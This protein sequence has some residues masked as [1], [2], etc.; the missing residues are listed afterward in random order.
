M[1]RLTLKNLAGNR[2]RFALTAFAVVLAVSFVVASFI[3]TDGLRAQF[4]GLSTEIVGG[5]DLAVRPVEG[6]FGRTGPLPTTMLA[7]VA[8]V[9]G[10]ANASP[11]LGGADN[12]IRP[13]KPDGSLISA[14]GPPQLAIGWSGEGTSSSFS[15]VEGRA[16]SGAGEFTMDLDG[17]AKNGFEVGHTY[18]LVTPTG[19]SE[20]TLTGT[21]RFGPDN[22]TL[23]AVLMQFPFDS[24]QSLLGTSGYDAI[25][26]DLAPGVERST[27]IGRISAVA[28]GA[29]VVDNATLVSEQQAN[30]NQ[31]INILG[32]VLLGFAGVSLFVS[33]FII[34]NTFSIVLGQRTRELGLLRLVGADPRQLRRSVLGE[35]LVIGVLASAIGIGAGVLVSWGLQG[36]FSAIGASL[37]DIP[38]VI[39]GRTVLVAVL[40]GVGATLVSAI[41]PARKA[42]RVAPIVAL[43]DGAAAGSSSGPVRLTVGGLLL[44]AGVALV[45]LGLFSANGAAPVSLLLAGGAA[46]VFVGIT[47][48]SPL[49]AVPLTRALGWPLDRSAGVSG[50]LAR[51]NAGRNP[52]RTATTAAALMIGLAAVTMALTV[53]ESVKA[54]FRSTLA[55]SVKADYIV[56]EDSG[57][58]F[59]GELAASFR[60][61]PLVADATEFRSDRARINGELAE[62]VGT[63][64]AGVPNLFD[65]HATSGSLVTAGV[66]DPVA[67]T[68]EE[69]ASK[70]LSVGDVIPT[71]FAS[72]QSRDLTVVAIYTD[73]TIIGAPYL[74][75]FGTWEAV[76]AEPTDSWMGVGLQPGA[77]Q[78]QGGQLV[79]DVKA[80]FPQ[81]TIDTPGQFADRVA[82]FVD[83][84][85]AAVNV[86]VALAV[87][88]A[89]IGIAN[90]LALSVFERTR[91][92]GLLRAVGMSRRQLRRM[93]RL[94]AALVALFGAALGVGAGIAFGWA[95][96]EALPSGITGA[97]SIP[98]GRIAVLV[99]VSGLA[100][101][102]AALGPARRASRLNLLDAIAH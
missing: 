78:A 44:A 91:E 70:G 2:V 69:A 96:V 66:N 88:I 7:Q 52:H 33:I 28:P 101:L 20:F 18:Q 79:A 92:L 23:G 38:V 64:L 90:T 54:Q 76:G 8:A 14:N 15:M 25:S 87:I 35:A 31:G 16:P 32:N 56:T 68:N 81:V 19:T 41:G 97:L 84:A 82:G 9:D 1:L 36:L 47:L 93:I 6:D 34:Y 50:R 59:P 94:E 99:V 63:D 43:R 45:G 24:L 67:V 77:D 73:D 95:A 40:V 49:L 37:P 98:A 46:G 27:V 3:L 83:Q 75:D 42:S 29:E 74:L 26:V 57:N 86:L 55:S 58:G 21:T 22:A 72:G 48:L 5:T 85:L 30:F 11:V 12:A 62:V 17:A 61:S 102:L 89:L 13:I 10:V 71:E 60:Q 4:N 100:G 39:S 65:L 53:G 51:Q 80:A